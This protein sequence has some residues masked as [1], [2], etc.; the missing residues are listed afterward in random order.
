M[1]PA[2][3]RG[4]LKSAADSEPAEVNGNVIDMDEQPAPGRGRRTRKAPSAGKPPARKST[5][6]R[7]SP[8]R[9]RKTPVPA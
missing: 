8:S 5:G 1:W 6:A 2:S 9:R 4:G 7:T 3:I